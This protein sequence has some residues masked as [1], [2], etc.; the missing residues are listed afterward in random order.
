MFLDWVNFSCSED[1]NASII[2]LDATSSLEIEY[3]YVDLTLNCI[4]MWM[5]AFEYTQVW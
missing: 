2:Q 3:F 5:V 1:I 4:E